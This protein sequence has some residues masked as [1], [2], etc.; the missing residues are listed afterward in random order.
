MRCGDPHLIEIPDETR[1]EIERKKTMKEKTLENINCT[2]F[3]S[4]N[5]EDELW[6]GG[7]FTEAVTT[8]L[9]NIATGASFSDA[10]LD[11]STVFTVDHVP[12]P[13]QPSSI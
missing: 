4:F 9:T 1:M 7:G 10:I 6:V 5:P 2:L 8:Q 3:D 12:A 11:S 13:A